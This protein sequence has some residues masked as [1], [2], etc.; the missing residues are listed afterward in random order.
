[1]TEITAAPAR[2]GF[3]ARINWVDLGPFIALAVLVAVGFLVNPDFIS[4]ANMANVITRS[5]FIAII[6][7]GAPS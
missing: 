6:A 3:F 2:E 5:A 1:M 7:V 4:P